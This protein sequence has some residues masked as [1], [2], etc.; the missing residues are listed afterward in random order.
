MG[1]TSKEFDTDIPAGSA[2]ADTLDTVI[3]D[4]MTAI[5]ERYA[6]EHVS[7]ISAASTNEDLATSAGRHKPGFIKSVLVDT[8]AN[9]AVAVSGTQYKGALGFDDSTGILYIHNGTNWTTLTVASIPTAASALT[10]RAYA[11]GVTSA[12]RDTWTKVLFATED[13][14][15]GSVFAGS[16]YTPVETGKYCLS[17]RVE[18]TVGAPTTDRGMVIAIYKNGSIYAAGNFTDWGYDA[19]TNSMMAAMISTDVL[20]DNA[21]DYFEVYIRQSAVATGKTVAATS[22]TYFTG[23]KVSS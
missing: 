23:R 17:A 4:L 8:I 19:T 9:I 10:F 12:T 6:L 16:T 1:N 3:Q 11:S 13:W 5:D 2:V 18:V 7:L 15:D 14:D 20:V 22:A 21:A